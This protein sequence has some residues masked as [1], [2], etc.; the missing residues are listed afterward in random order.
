MEKTKEKSGERRGSGVRARNPIIEVPKDH[1]IV[2]RDWLEGILEELKDVRAVRR[3]RR[4]K[5]LYT[6]AQVKR[7]LKRD[8]KI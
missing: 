8:G 7:D 3:A 4:A 2:S 6:L 1:V 5:K